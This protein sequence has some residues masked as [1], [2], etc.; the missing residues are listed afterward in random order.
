MGKDKVVI[1]SKTAL[2]KSK[3]WDAQR[4]YYTEQGINAWTD[5]VPFYV[6][7][8]PVIAHA[9]AEMVFRFILDCIDIDH[10]AIDMPFYIV[11]IGVGPG[12]FSYYVLKRLLA[13]IAHDGRQIKIR[14]IMSDITEKNL[15]FWQKHAVL[16]PYLDEGVIDF[17][18]YD[19]EKDRSI[20]LL[21]S[22]E[23]LASGSLKNPLIVFANYL[24]DSVVA[25]VF[26]VSGDEL[27]AS[28][29]NLSTDEGNLDAK[30]PRNWEK[31]TVG[32]EDEL[33]A[34]D[35]YDDPIV[36]QLLT[37]YRGLLSDSY[38]HFPIGSIRGLKALAAL[39]DNKMLLLASD[40][41]Y[42]S[43]DELEELE[44][45]ELAFHGSFS[46]MVNFHAIS[47]YFDMLGGSSYMQQPFDGFAT[48]A[49]M[50]GIESS[51]MPRANAMLQEQASGFCPGHYFCLYEHMEKTYEKADLPA[52]ASFLTLSHWDPGIFE[53]FSERIGDLVEGADE[54]VV[55][56]L[57]TNLPRVADNFYFVPGAHD[58]LFDIAV[59]Y[60]EQSLY[61][62][63]ILYF[64]KSRV[65]FEDT[66]EV[67]FNIGYC[68][69]ELGQYTAAKQF[70]ELAVAFDS[71]SREASDW[72][73]NTLRKIEIA[74]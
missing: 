31:V 1:E 28:L 14:Y 59:F 52:L 66:Y 72:L 30:S 27:Y 74:S 64:K 33:V 73:R 13:L 69:S 4:S 53:M 55:K 19:I 71:A 10:E 20:D 40:K 6:T 56:Y 38:L 18:K 45:P 17:A 57:A 29:V 70:F 51:K 9:Y 54:D 63:A 5:E 42:V 43:V 21:V 2:S 7:S 46:L 41:G 15:N 34:D 60:H 50:L 24:F 68:Y 26:K 35:Y 61:H 39:S 44:H 11:E 58:V 67:L 47:S 8:N 25:D 62:E 22:G 12:Q 49:F 32:Y 48:G 37:S 23:T 65:Y 3:L 16:K 36:D